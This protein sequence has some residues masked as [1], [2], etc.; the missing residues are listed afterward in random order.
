M[1][2]LDKKFSSLIKLGGVPYSPRYCTVAP[3][4]E[5]GDMGPVL[6]CVTQVLETCPR[7]TC[8]KYQARKVAYI[9]PSSGSIFYHVVV[10]IGRPE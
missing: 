9:G 5:I 2:F 3:V 10:P 4:C 1:G 8:Q 7:F 6:L